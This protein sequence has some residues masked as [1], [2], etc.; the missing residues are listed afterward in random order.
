M[1]GTTF[2]QLLAPHVRVHMVNAGEEEDLRL[3]VV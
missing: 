3:S 2:D 1:L